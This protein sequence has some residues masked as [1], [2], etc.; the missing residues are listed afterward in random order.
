MGRFWVFLSHTAPGF[1]LW[2]YFHIYMGVVHWGVAP[3]AAWRAWVC[4]CEA[5]CGGAAA[6]W[7][8][9]VLAA[10]GTQGGW[11]LGQQEYSALEGYHNQYWTMRSSILA[12]R[13]P[14]LMEKPVRS[15][16][17]GSQRAGQDRSD[18]ARIAARHFLACGS[19]APLRFECEGGPVAWL[20]GALVVPSVQRRRLP[21]PRDL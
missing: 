12:W 17:T 14:S 16:S 4:P 13:P 7:V 2:F 6:A 3:E 15:Q 5:R 18:P 10:P 19:S 9:G 1:Q 20:A 8:T 21:L 11:W